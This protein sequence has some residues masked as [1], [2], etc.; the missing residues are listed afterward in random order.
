M[1]PRRLP[2]LLLWCCAS[3]AAAAAP[4][5]VSSPQRTPLTDV[6]ERAALYVSEYETRVSAVVAEEHYL[7]E[8]KT[9]GSRDVKGGPTF[10]ARELARG[11]EPR[12]VYPG[13]MGR[14]KQEGALKR[15]T[16]S[17]VLMV[18]LADRTWF[19]F[20][21]VI[22]VDGHTVRDR[23]GRLQEL[24]LQAQAS[25]KR[26]VDESA[27]YNIG[28]IHRNTNLPTFALLYLAPD[29]QY[30]FMF[31]KT[32]E[33]EIDGVL[34]WIVSFTEVK[35][36]TIVKDDRGRNVPSTGRFWIVPDSGQV[37]RTEL[38]TGNATSEARGRTVV[39]YQ[40]NATLGMPVP[41][42]MKEIYDLPPRPWDPYVECTA[43]YSN[44]RRF[45]V[46]TDTKIT[47]PK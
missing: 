20:R 40:S 44:Y 10:D 2:A 47:I 36:S 23:E 42:V 11:E 28:P 39:A 31:D 18:Q 22:E 6:L 37:L 29:F 17:D 34:T 15:R 16:R 25:T 26:I 14:Q 5:L 32:G 27:R 45:Q 38:I 8:V 4:A 3:A 35:E 12:D 33:E 46:T 41:A 7:Q 43:V 21:D 30:R 9:G 13:S 24:F 19:G 1:A